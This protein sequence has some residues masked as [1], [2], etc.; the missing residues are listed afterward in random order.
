MREQDACVVLAGVGKGY[1][2][3]KNVLARMLIEMRNV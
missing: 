1:L 2:T 3:N